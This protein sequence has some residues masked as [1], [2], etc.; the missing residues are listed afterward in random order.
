VAFLCGLAREQST[1]S[2]KLKGYANAQFLSPHRYD[3]SAGR[4]RLSDES[5][6]PSA[7]TVI[8]DEGSMLTEEMLAALIQALMGVHRILLIG[9]PRQLPPID[10]GRPFV[11]RMIVPFTVRRPQG[12]ENRRALCINRQFSECV[13]FLELFPFE[14]ALRPQSCD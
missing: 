8:I 6:E 9:D 13:S 7:R 4:Y 12:T 3:G 11:I 2:L 14:R 10:A 1:R 5:T